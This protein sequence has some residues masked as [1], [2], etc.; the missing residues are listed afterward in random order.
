MKILW[1]KS[2]GLFPP[3]TGGKIRSYHILRELARRHQV[4]LFL[5]YHAEKHDRHKELE[6]RFARL[7]CRPVQEA[8]RKTWAGRSAYVRN[9]FSTR[10]HSV[11]R[12][13][14]P[15][16]L[17]VLRQVAS[18]EEF[19][20][21][22][23]DFVMSAPV[24][25]WEA[26]A[27]KI[28]FAHN[29]ETAL[30]RRYFRVA[31]NPIRKLISWREYQTM[32]WT[33][34]EYAHAADH[35]ITVSEADR[36]FFSEL[37]GADRTTAIPTGV[38]LEYFRPLPDAEEEN[39]IVFT[40]SM[41]WPPN[42]DGVLFFSQKI[43]PLIQRSIPG[44]VLWIVGRSPSGNVL[45]LAS[46]D[47]AIHVTGTVQDIRPYVNRAAVYVVPLRVGGGTRLKIFEAMAMGK[48]VVSTTIGAEGLPI[49]DGHNVL[50]ADA[51]E[52]FAEQ[53]IRLL[54][55]RSLRNDLGNA[56]R[57]LVEPQYGWPQVASDCEVVFERA[58][59]KFAEKKR[60]T[61]RIEPVAPV[62]VG[63]PA[64]WDAPNEVLVEE[65]PSE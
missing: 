27:P 48:A 9:F 57:K 62:A 44:A 15:D 61:P 37:V 5:S 32:L 49:T 58:V 23:C 45:R 7:I 38:D 6:T 16:M 51:P 22:V 42:E 26:D 18:E 25:P 46:Q 17:G 60:L 29:V 34:R 59:Q 53:T 8:S 19:D 21:I 1:V 40:G 47:P 11:A 13:C 28:L 3:D 24:I 20:V 64:N 39:N 12:F 30:W 41:D 65:S 14:R 33:E 35:V 36:R 31:R 4:T 63:G 54:Q 56:A 43:L 55:N 52:R 10:P 50:I 2:G